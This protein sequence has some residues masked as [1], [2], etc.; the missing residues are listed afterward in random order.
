M[1]QSTKQALDEAAKLNAYKEN[2]LFQLKA[3]KKLLKV[4]IL[5]IMQDFRSTIDF[6]TEKVMSSA[7]NSLIDDPTLKKS[8]KKDKA[9]LEV[10]H[11]LNKALKRI[12][13]FAEEIK[14]Q[15]GELK[16]NF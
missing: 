12:G 11:N 1:S 16:D 3:S 9:T 2:I 4:E 14:T 10:Y 7:A 15:F 6:M 13:V 8:S 5:E